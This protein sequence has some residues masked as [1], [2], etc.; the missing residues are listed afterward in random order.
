MKQMMVVM[1]LALGLAGCSWQDD[2]VI[3]GQG[4]TVVAQLPLGD[5]VDRILAVVPADIRLVHGSER[6][7]RLEGQ[8]NLLPY[9]TFSESGRKL[10]IEVKEGYRLSTDEGLKVTITLPSLR[11]LALAGSSRAE[12]GAFEEDE[13]TLSL[14]GSGGIRTDRLEVRSLEG[15]IAGSG[16]LALGQG[17]ADS[18]TFNI[19]GSGGIAAGELQ[20]REVEIKIAG[21][22]DVAV[23]AAQRLTATIAGSGNIDYW[24]DPEIE[25]EIAGSGQLVRQGG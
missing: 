22:G 2:E 14:A 21:S 23:R 16:D 1:V 20:A 19:A 12:V 11:E 17:H 15:N 25:S 18:L 8:E 7:I 4:A 13:L 24:G 5:R 10:E 9:L 6:G 3:R